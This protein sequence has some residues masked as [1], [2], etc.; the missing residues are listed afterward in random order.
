MTLIIFF[1]DR[2]G[3]DFQSCRYSYQMTSASAT[4]VRSFMIEE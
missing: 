4:V 3:H 1:T 2:G